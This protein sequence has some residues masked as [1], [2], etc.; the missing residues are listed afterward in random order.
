MYDY[1]I[2]K[3]ALEIIFKGNAQE[4]KAFLKN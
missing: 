1:Q 3:T 2:Q 4:I